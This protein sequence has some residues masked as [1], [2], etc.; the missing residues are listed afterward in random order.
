MNGT[1]KYIRPEKSIVWRVL[2]WIAVVLLGMAIMTGWWRP[3]PRN[4]LASDE[5]LIAYFFAHRA[6]IEELVKRYREYQ[7][8]PGQGHHQWRKQGDTAERFKRA[9]VRDITYNVTVWFPNPYSI[10]TAKQVA[11]TPGF[12]KYIKHGGIRVQ[13]DDDRFMRN[14]TI[15]KDLS[16]IPEIP[17]IENGMLLYP[18]DEQGRQS[19][20]R[21]LPTLNS[22]P[23]EVQRDECALRQIEPQWFIRMCRVID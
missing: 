8:P 12:E 19:R 5:E 18:V 7:P 1:T 10:E 2:L 6:D 15:W 17:R 22:E 3:L 13:I 4:N 21:V 16:F 9:G 14:S 11:A 23:P 20:D